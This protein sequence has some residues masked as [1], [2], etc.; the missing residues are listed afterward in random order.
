MDIAVRDTSRAIRW[1][2]GEGI[3]MDVAVRDT[4]RAIKWMTGEGI[5]MDVAIRD[6]PRVPEW[7]TGEGAG[8]GVSIR[9]ILRARSSPRAHS[10]RFGD[11]GLGR[12]GVQVVRWAGPVFP[13]AP[14]SAAVAVRE[15]RS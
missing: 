6:P 14:A 3:G 9:E 15:W 1:M 2:T 13:S 8:M 11:S 4:S 5:G 12:E 10:F 7:M